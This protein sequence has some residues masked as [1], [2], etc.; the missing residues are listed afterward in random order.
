MKKDQKIKPFPPGDYFCLDTKVTKKSR[1]IRN[2]ICNREY[3]ISRVR[4]M[5]LSF[6]SA[7]EVKQ[8]IYFLW[9]QISKIITN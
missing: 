1:P 2:L 4:F 6:L 5:L 3:A 8:T 7:G 9:M